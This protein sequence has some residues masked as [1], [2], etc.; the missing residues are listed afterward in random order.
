MI[1]NKLLDA[2]NMSMYK[3]SKLSGVSQAAISDICSGK[4]TLDKCSVGTLRRIA[5]VFGVTMDNIIEAEEKEK[6]RKTEHRCSF[7]VYK[8]T[9]CHYVK[10]NG[11]IPFIINILENNRIRKLYEKKWY[12]EAFYLLAMLDYLSRIN[13]I[14]ICN[15]YNDIRKRKFNQIVYPTGI[16][17]EAKITK[18]SDI[19]ERALLNAIPEFI[20]YNIVEAEVRNIV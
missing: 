4:T 12:P 11:D 7:E 5:S 13:A 2:E 1:I 18:N 17:L 9:I 20:R 19:K 6:E 16:L 14:P 10:E 3:L 15:D 8:S